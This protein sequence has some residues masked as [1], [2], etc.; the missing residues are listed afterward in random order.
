MPS[1][2]TTTFRL[3]AAVNAMLDALVAADGT[4]RTAVLKRLVLEETRRRKRRVSD[5]QGG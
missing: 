2:P 3:G 1:T 5:G 4:N